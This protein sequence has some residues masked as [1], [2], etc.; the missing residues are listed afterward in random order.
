M[1]LPTFLDPTQLENFPAQ[2]TAKTL[3]YKL[4][5][6]QASLTVFSGL[7]QVFRAMVRW[8]HFP[9]AALYSGAFMSTWEGCALAQCHSEGGN[10]FVDLFQTSQNTGWERRR[11]P[12]LKHDPCCQTAYHNGRNILYGWIHTTTGW[13]LYLLLHL[14]VTFS[15]SLSSLRLSICICKMGTENCLNVTEALRWWWGCIEFV[16]GLLQSLSMWAPEWLMQVLA[17]WPSSDICH[18]QISIYLSFLKR[19]DLILSGDY[20]R[21]NLKF[22]DVVGCAQETPLVSDMCRLK[23]SS[24]P[25]PLCWGARY[26]QSLVRL[27]G[28]H[29]SEV[30]LSRYNPWAQ[31]ELQ[32]S[33]LVLRATVTNYHKSGGFKHQR[34]CKLKAWNQDVCKAGSL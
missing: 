16:S 18:L 19:K 34:F 5:S 17:L 28:E 4:H 26:S 20:Q 10:A 22:S 2:W 24:N 29:N 1:K 33:L 9:P 23:P 3:F 21:V 30:T 11:C 6:S 27:L 7:I 14:W 31:V 25:G 12:S 32:G 8:F 13:M 15:E